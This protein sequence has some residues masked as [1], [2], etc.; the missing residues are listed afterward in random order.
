MKHFVGDEIE[1]KLDVLC[2]REPV[3]VLEGSWGHG[4]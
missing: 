1:F 3:K 2:D 4:S